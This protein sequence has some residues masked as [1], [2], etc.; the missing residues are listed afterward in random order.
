MSDSKV[1]MFPETGASN[2]ELISLLSP[3]HLH[4]IKTL[5]CKLIKML[6]EHSE[7]YNRD[8]DDYDDEDEFEA[9]GRM[10]RRSKGRYEY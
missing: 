7:A 3:E 9:R 8:K 6:A 1:F 2:G 4:R 5:A 10:G